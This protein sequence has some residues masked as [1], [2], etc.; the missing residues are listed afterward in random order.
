[1]GRT[2][3]VALALL[4]LSFG[5]IFVLRGS[6]WIVLGIFAVDVLAAASYVWVAFWYANK[7]PQFATV[8]GAEVVRY[9]ELQQSAK[10]PAVIEG[11]ATPIANTAPP[12]AITIG[13][14]DA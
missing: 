7:Y 11:S 3:H 13:G 2:S 5:A 9:T 10:E 1:M 6:P 4:L 8:E 12:P 14:N